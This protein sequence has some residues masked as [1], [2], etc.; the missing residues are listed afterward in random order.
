MDPENIPYLL[1]KIGESIEN[2]VADTLKNRDEDNKDKKAAR[3]AERTEFPPMRYDNMDYMEPDWEDL[4]RK[5]DLIVARYAVVSAAWNVLPP[6]ADVIGVTA[7]F[8]KM[9]TELAGVYQ[10]IVSS[11]RARQMGWAIATTTASVLG[12]TYAGSRLVRL[13]PGGY[14]PSL[15]IQAPIIGAVA[16]A[17]GDA[18][19]GYFKQARMGVEPSIAS[20]RDSFAKTL[21]LKLKKVKVDEVAADAP[22]AATV[23]TATTNG[24]SAKASEPGSVT[25]VVE[26]I[27]GL[28]ELLRQGAITQDEFDRKKADL[29][30]KL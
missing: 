23:A 26:K 8:S 18:L 5:A 30:S 19:K 14:L 3:P 7:T 2:K 12:I 28:H 22:S 4:D 1:R 11:K 29:L 10:V 27:A 13:I 25:D 15:L 6:P 20:L 17:A 21:R 9:T 24:E 16:W